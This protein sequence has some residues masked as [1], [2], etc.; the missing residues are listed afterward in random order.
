MLVLLAI[1]FLAGVVTA[2]S[3]CVLPILP[4]LAVVTVIAAHQDVG[5][6]AIALT[7]AYALGAAVPMLAVAIGGQ[8]ASI[9]LRANAAR[10]RIAAGAVI[11]LTALALTL[12]LDEHLRNVPGYTNFLQSKIES[13][14]TARRELAKLSGSKSLTARDSASAGLP[15]YGAA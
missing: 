11:A 10:F 3:P 15:D 1:G 5:A 14:G 12:N 9:R 6:R 8:R 2:I 7:L 4:V 13:N